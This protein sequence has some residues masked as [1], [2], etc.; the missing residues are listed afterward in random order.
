[1]SCCI[2]TETCLPGTISPFLELVGDDDSRGPRVVEFPKMD[3]E[4]AGGLLNLRSV[5]AYIE[6]PE[7]GEGERW[8]LPYSDFLARW[9][10][11]IP[12]VPFWMIVAHNLDS[13]NVDKV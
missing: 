9:V 7:V 13:E 2:P 1:V 12:V 10:Q 5:P 4:W 6:G 11:V 3:E 8:P